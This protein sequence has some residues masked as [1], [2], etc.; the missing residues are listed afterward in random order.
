M[1]LVFHPD[2]PLKTLNTFGMDVR[3]ATF[4][5]LDDLT[6]LPTLLASEPYRRGPVL[7]LGGGSNLLFTGDYPGLVV[8]VALT[9]ITV[10]TEDDDEVVVEA[11]A[12]ENWHSFVQHTLTQGWAG[13]E[14][15]SL[16]PGTVG[17]SPIQNIGAYG[18]E[19]KDC[20]TE[21]V[22]ADLQDNGAQRVLSSA[23][24]RFGYRD[25][26]FKH[27]ASGRLLVTAVRFRLS[28]RPSLHTG[29]GDIGTELAAMGKADGAS[30]RDVSDAV[31]RIRSAKL[32]NPLELGNAGSFFKN[33]IIAT[34]LAEALLARH[35]DL[36]HYPAGAG[37]TKLAA[38]WLIDRAGLKG[39][40]EGDAGVHARQALVLVNYGHASGKEVWAL[41]QKVQATVKERYGVEL[42]P[43][44]LV[45]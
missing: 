26:V 43:E 45:L 3:A 1:S 39:Y 5:E 2:H 6:Q 19:V 10:L 30:P 28:K 25:S 8:K 41:A 35:P 27:E 12:G 7:W 16:I 31:I 24:C 29:Y 14:N 40:R 32:P 37:K 13:L 34:E 4:C 17:A 15:L 11:A 44:P 33:P 36:P 22:C 23:D 20:L 38:G 9:G 18:V 42:E 21:V